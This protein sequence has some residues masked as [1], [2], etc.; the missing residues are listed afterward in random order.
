MFQAYIL[1]LEINKFCMASGYLV[2]GK[3]EMKLFTIKFNER[4]AVSRK[5][6]TTYIYTPR[7]TF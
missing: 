1:I 5:R 6:Y 3:F 7:C 4:Q 2:A